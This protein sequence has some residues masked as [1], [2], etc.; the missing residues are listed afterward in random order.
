MLNGETL[1][2]Q[3]ADGKSRSHGQ[4]VVM[5][6]ENE[7]A[8]NLIQI[9]DHKSPEHPKAGA[10]RASP[11][12]PGVADRYTPTMPPAT[13]TWTRSDAHQQSV[14]ATLT[15]TRVS[16]IEPVTQGGP[17]SQLP[18]LKPRLGKPMRRS[19]DRL[20][21]ISWE[22]AVREIGDRMRS[23]RSQ[24]AETAILAGAR[25]ATDSA[26]MV[27]TLAT[28]LA[29][30]PACLH[31]HLAD[32]GAPLV[33][34]AE[35]VIGHPVLLQA[36]VAR[37]H[38]AVLMGANQSAAGWGPMQVA[39]GMEREL[40]QARKVK[41]NK[42]ISIDPRKPALARGSDQHL[43]IRPGTDLYCLLGMCRHILDNG[44]RD[45][46]FTRDW[47]TG[48]EELTAALAPWTLDRCAAICGVPAGDLGGIALKF[49]RAAMA[50]VH[51]SPQALRGQ[52]ATLT[53]WASL[54]LHALTANLLRPGGLYENKGIGPA[55]ALM[56]EFGTA[57]APELAGRPLLLTQ[58][59]AHALTERILTPSHAQVRGLLCL[60]ADPATELCGPRV[61]AALRSLDLLVAIDTVESATT[62][63]AHFVLPT[64][65]PF[66]REDIRLLDTVVLPRRELAWTPALEPAPGGARSTDQILRDVYRTQRPT[67]KSP[68]GAHVRLRAAMVVRSGT[69]SWFEKALA[70]TPARSL[71]ALKT[72]AWDGGDVDRATWRVSFDDDRLRLLPDPIGRALANLSEPKQAP[73]QTHWLLTSAAR[74]ALLSRADRDENEDP[75]VT[76]HPDAGYSDGERVIVHTSTGSVSALVRNDPELRADTVD[77]PAGYA[78]PVARLIPDD[79]LD[80]FVGTPAWDGLGCSIARDG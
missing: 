40:A 67:L 51:L 14:L 79:L 23:I 3:R 15:G 80:A 5:R 44:W 58:A 36:D 69:T 31:T 6:V 55:A 50:V 21:E 43:P 56:T 46:Q 30:G 72:G 32:F 53:A 59:S 20:E 60:S 24:Q 64:L 78:T 18:A 39:P 52:N 49:S 34:A 45:V 48:L 62:R 61:D 42:L 25:V 65:A 68:F 35:L 12:A 16:S 71:A 19:G 11:R 33:R 47:T 2:I 41:S 38:Y 29:L 22:A 66:E 37:A 74:D 27:R 57:K 73:G 63:L 75:G 1:G 13:P 54:V 70:T 10:A 77:L 17:R 8:L 26:A 4:R 9:R 7:C 28:Q 76:L